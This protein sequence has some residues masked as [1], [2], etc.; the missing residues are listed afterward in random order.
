MHEETPP[1]L[2]SETPPAAQRASSSE[3]A[4]VEMVESSLTAPAAPPPAPPQ[5]PPLAPSEP[6]IGPRSHGRRGLESLLVRVVATCGIIGI[7]VAVAAVLGTQD[8]HV[9]VIGLV[10]AALSVVLAAVLWSS[11]T[12]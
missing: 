5:T 8:V 3:D 11:R 2:E 9:W 4:R 12:L 6:F 1:H 7:G 10:V